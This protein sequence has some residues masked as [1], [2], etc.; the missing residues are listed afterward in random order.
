FNAI[1]KVLENP[2]T[3]VKITNTDQ[4]L[5]EQQ[6]ILTRNARYSNPPKVHFQRHSHSHPRCPWPLARRPYRG[7]YSIHGDW[8]P[9][10]PH[11]RLTCLC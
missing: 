5:Q 8:H 9:R 6:P 2:E 4:S 10:L 1:N 3:E 7:D 11:H